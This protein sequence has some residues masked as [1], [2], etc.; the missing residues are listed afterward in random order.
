MPIERVSASGHFPPWVRHEHQARYIFAADQA[1]GKIVVDCACGDGSSTRLIA[2][3]AREVYAFD[4]SDVAIEQA[5]AATNPDNVRFAVADGVS[6]P[7]PDATAD[8][9][10]SLE[11]IEHLPDEQ[12]FLKEVV[13]VLKPDGVF[14]CSTPDRDVYSPG[15]TLSSQPWKGFHVREWTQPEFSSLLGGHFETV[16]MFGQ[17]PKTPALVSLR[18]Q[19]GRH[20]PWDLVVRMNQAL[21]MPRYLYDRLEHHPVIPVSNGRRYEALTAVCRGPRAG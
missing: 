15:H 19:V 3:R 6:L 16:D 2:E 11:T 10:V 13:R 1:E 5:R 21:K 7:L 17:N 12:P 4:L 20:V 8:L 18:C 14:I 9:F